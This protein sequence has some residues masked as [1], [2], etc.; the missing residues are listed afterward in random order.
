[1]AQQ[2]FPWGL[3][4]GKNVVLATPSYGRLEEYAWAGRAVIAA[5]TARDY[6]HDLAMLLGEHATGLVPPLPE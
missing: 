6:S 4:S 2:M 1:M 5:T 3:L